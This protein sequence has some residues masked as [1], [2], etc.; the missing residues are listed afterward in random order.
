M[1]IYFRQFWRD[2]RLKYLSAHGLEM[3]VLSG[4]QK[5]NCPIWVPDTFFVNEN[6]AH[7]HQ[8]TVPNEYT[9]IFHNGDVLVSQRL[10]NN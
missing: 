1:D 2:P 5:T 8:Q 7:V 6:T 9:K 10:R 4:E 3:I